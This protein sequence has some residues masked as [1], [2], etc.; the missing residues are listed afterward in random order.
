MSI[1]NFGLLHPGE[2]GVTVGI[3]AQSSTEVLWLDCERSTSTQ[4]RAKSASLTPLSS[5]RSLVDKSDIIFCVCP[6]H[7]AKQVAEEVAQASFA[8]LYVDANALSPNNV[9]E[10]GKI[11]TNSGADFV[12]GSLVGP[13]AKQVGTTRLYLSGERAEEVSII[14]D[15]SMLDARVI[16]TEIGKAS[17]LKM[18]YAAWTKGTDALLIAIRALAAFEGV[19]QALVKEWNQSQAG[20]ETQSLNAISNS[21]PKGWR[22]TS[23]MHEIAGTF[24]ANNLPSGFHEAANDIYERLS[25]FK[26]QFQPAPTLKKVLE[27]LQSPQSSKVDDVSLFKKE[28]CGKSIL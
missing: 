19:D 11:I 21:A 22:Y 25:V 28:E 17:A 23:E 6:P 14:F 9:C 1:S 4:K 3:A 15:G 16:S 13:P 7:G 27:S 8:G 24:S 26:D 10:I 5:F 20:L 2:M 12:D 18:A